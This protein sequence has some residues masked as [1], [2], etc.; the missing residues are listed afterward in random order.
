LTDL[1]A[2]R[3]AYRMQST[4]PKVLNSRI[5]EQEWI[6]AALDMLAKG[7]LAAVRIEPLA[8]KL[9]VTKGAFYARYPTRDALLMAM[10]N[11]WRRVSTVDVF[12]G[13]AAMDEHPAQRLE[14]LVRLSTRRPDA[15]NRGLLE[16]GI[17]IWADTDARAAATMGE[18][19]AYRLNYFD[20]VLRAN[21]FEAVEAQA[22]ALLIYGYLVAD[23][24]LS[25]KRSEATKGLI[26]ALLT[27]DIVHD[28]PDQVKN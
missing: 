19:D 25:G 24:C 4:T 27:A 15:R 5:D 10:L 1:D 7:G 9:G 28:D 12:E 20:A 13:F 6:E 11:Y 16:M 2:V 18:I 23:A 3:I 17:R 21:G 26:R 14:R 22:R 8:L